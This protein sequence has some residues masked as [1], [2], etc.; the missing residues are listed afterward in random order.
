M[1]DGIIGE[2]ELNIGRFVSMLMLAIPIL[3][4]QKSPL[5][6]AKKNRISVLL[7]CLLIFGVNYTS[8]ASTIYI[9]SG[10]S[11]AAYLVSFMASSLLVTT[12][13]TRCTERQFH[14]L[15]LLY[16]AV[17]ILLLS[18]G[19]ILLEQPA[20]LFGKKP[21]TPYI[22]FCNPYRFE[23][24]F[25]SS[26]TTQTMGNTTTM[27]NGEV[28][29]QQ[30]NTP[31]FSLLGYFYAIAAGILMVLYVL[32]GTHIFRTEPP[33][34]VCTWIGLIDT[35][36]S[37]LCTALFES[38]FLPKDLIC[39]FV[40]I[41]HALFTGTM[42]VVCLLAVE[43]VPSTDLSFINSLSVAV[44]FCFQFSILKNA[45]PSYSPVNTLS[46]VAAILVTIVSLLKPLIECLRLRTKKET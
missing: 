12:V 36:L 37:V 4:K 33:I 13:T 14:C 34:V 26:L 18:L 22:S 1:L 11:N 8:Y 41:F 40:F 9:P 42:S 43:N 39:N 25:N 24:S 44:V 23:D 21:Q 38:F 20:L 35:V 31:M 10:T 16:N 7:L 45:S 27:S 2:F 6:I 3:T 19:I 28:Q 30:P 46:I 15:K 29:Q 5:V 32:L 17:A